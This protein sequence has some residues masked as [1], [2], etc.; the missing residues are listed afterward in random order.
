MG[1]K[2]KKPIVKW[3]ITPT[4]ATMWTLKDDLEAGVKSGAINI[5]NNKTACCSVSKYSWNTFL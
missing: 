3:M 1:K 2:M 5:K 4:E